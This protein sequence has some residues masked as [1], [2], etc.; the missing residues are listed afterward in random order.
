MATKL[1]KVLVQDAF[2]ADLDLDNM[3][4]D[5][6]FHDNDIFDPFMTIV[7]HAYPKLMYPQKFF[8]A[9]KNLNLTCQLEI[10]RLA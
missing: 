8:C 1:V 5:S 9:Q 4:K 3:M 7:C 10:I 6:D 2:I